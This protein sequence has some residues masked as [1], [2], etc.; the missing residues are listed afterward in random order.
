[1]KQFCDERVKLKRAHQ[2]GLRGS[3][4]I[5]R[6]LKIEKEPYIAWEGHSSRRSNSNHGPEVRKSLAYSRTYQKATG[7][8]KGSGFR[9]A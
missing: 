7:S 8:K 4:N 5:I 9:K 6:Y 1:M 3:L 2:G